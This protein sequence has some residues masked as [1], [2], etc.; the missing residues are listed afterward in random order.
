MVIVVMTAVLMVAIGI[1]S[2]LIHL[3]LV[4]VFVVFIVVM[5]LHFFA[6]RQQ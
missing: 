1:G 2:D 4:V 5:I 3:L 6:Y